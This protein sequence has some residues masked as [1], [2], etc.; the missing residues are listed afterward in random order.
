ME[1][2]AAVNHV[3][4]RKRNGE[5]MVW[6]ADEYGMPLQVP[7]GLEN[8]TAVASGMAHTLVMTS[9]G[10]LFC[11]RSKHLPNPGACQIPDFLIS[12][13]AAVQA[14]RASQ[15]TSFAQLN[16]R[17]GTWVAFG[18]SFKRFHPSRLA[19]GHHLAVV[20]DIV[21]WQAGLLLSF[22]G[23]GRLLQF[24]VQNDAPLPHW[25]EP[26]EHQP[27]II[28]QVCVL[29]GS[30]R[31][32][33]ALLTNGT[34]TVWPSIGSEVSDLQPPDIVHHGSL[35][36]IVCGA[37]HILAIAT[38]GRALAWGVNA[39]HGQLNVD[40]GSSMVVQSAAAGLYHSVL[41]SQGKVYQAGNVSS[42]A[43]NAL[44][45]ALLTPFGSAVGVAAGGDC[46]V[47]HMQGNVVAA[48]G[49]LYTAAG[50]VPSDVVN[51]PVTQVAAGANHIVVL[52]AD[53]SIVT[54]GA[55]GAAL[56]VPSQVR[57]QRTAFV[58]AG[59]GF[60]LAIASMT[61]KLWAW[62]NLPCSASD[63]ASDTSSISV[64]AVS[65]G[66]DHILAIQQNGSIL[67]YGCNEYG[68]TAAS[69]SIVGAQAVSVAAGRQ[70]SVVVLATGM[71][72]AY[73]RNDHGETI[74]PDDI[75]G[76]VLSASAGDHHALAMLKNR[77]LVSWG[78]DSLGQRNIPAEV[79]NRQVLSYSA[80]SKFS[81]AAIDPAPS[82][83]GWTPPGVKLLFSQSLTLG[84][85]A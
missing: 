66:Y 76:N 10:Q 33:A 46:A 53:G 42:E 20:S 28:A 22:P 31:G 37:S 58:A 27:G 56:Q 65:A 4:M 25:A 78:D 73:G 2:S 71:V 24:W 34:V 52:L 61:G 57:Q 48:W 21:E 74:V 64:S 50:N 32:V 41:V 47:A 62:G 11:V 5:L 67:S 8:I 69:E 7:S 16:D 23:G 17:L 44:P 39:T 83:G 84:G 49:D 35:T 26:L 38:D 6:G 72:M 63:L 55:S 85:R 1:I 68:Q 19:T 18:G 30:R 77:S 9:S 81:L 45:T 43:S 36:G 80:G 3:A 79:Q 82:A 59:N 13:K 60:S 75:Q 54:W 15:H 70:F 14:I 40:F 12:R 29:Q 51:S